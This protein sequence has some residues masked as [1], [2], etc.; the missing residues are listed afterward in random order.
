MDKRARLSGN[1]V[2]LGTLHKY[3]LTRYIKSAFVR[4]YHTLE[5]NPRR[6]NIYI[7]QFRGNSKGD[8]SKL[9]SFLRQRLKVEI[10]PEAFDENFR[11]HIT[12]Y[13]MT[14]SQD[15]YKEAEELE[16]IGYKTERDGRL[17]ASIAAARTAQERLGSG[18]PI[19]LLSSSYHLR[20]AENRF[21]EEFGRARVLFSIGALSYLLSS[22][23]DAGL[24]ADSLRMALFE[25]GR[26]ARLEDSERRALRIIRATGEYD[27]PWAERQL[28]ET[29]LN[30]AIR[31]EAEKRGIREAQ[32]RSKLNSGEEPRV[33][34]KLIAD[35]LR[36]MAL[37]DKTG[38]ELSEAQ[39]RINQLQNKILELE[40]T[41][42]SAKTGIRRP[43]P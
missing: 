36:D 39:G 16:D 41:L 38:E 4:T 2:L 43:T 27:I 14:S 1:Q 8:Y 32:L 24:G 5:K 37:K 19:V 10:L 9:L 21:R 12:Q 26:S 3:E 30:A 18:G 40:E 42:K 23:P 7:E 25:F 28:L 33:T 34:A 6:W 22:V 17:M 11:T 20:R 31:S 29:N 13:L 35:S 15:P